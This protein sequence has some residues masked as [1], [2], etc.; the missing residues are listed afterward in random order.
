LEFY[1]GDITDTTKSYLLRNGLYRN[2]GGID[3][4][5]V[6]LHV[7]GSRKTKVNY[8]ELSFVKQLTDSL[9]GETVY[10]KLLKTLKDSYGEAYTQH[11]EKF[12]PGAVAGT[13]NIV[14]VYLSENNPFYAVE[15]TKW[16]GYSNI[17]ISLHYMRENNLIIL[18]VN[19]FVTTGLTNNRARNWFFESE[20]DE[21]LTS[22]FK[23][24]DKSNGYKQ[25]KFGQ[26]KSMVKTLVSLK[27][28]NPFKEYEVLNLQYKSWFY[29][30]FD[31]CDVMFNKSNLLY[32]VSLTQPE[33]SD[34][35][36]QKFLDD[37]VEMFGPPNRYKKELKTEEYTMW[38]GKFI[39]I[40]VLRPNGKMSMFVD[41]NC[42][43]LDDSS[44]ADKLH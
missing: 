36:Y 8:N 2:F 23:D 17:Y 35:D 20:Y 6:I 25:L 28:P 30:R 41:F 38:T 39:K 13:T 14:R 11:L 7:N 3:F 5:R 43:R 34:E 33:F 19:E 21:N 24:F 16:E 4:D 9:E 31:E 10:A 26:P 18:T 12:K 15:E 37:L 42:P 44:P 22:A 27:G 32:D 1:C 40:L 29:I